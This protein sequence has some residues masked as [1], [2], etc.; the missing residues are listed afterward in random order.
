ML[1]EAPTFHLVMLLRRLFIYASCVLVIENAIQQQVL[2]W[3]RDHLI[4]YL[5]EAAWLE[6]AF[7]LPAWIYLISSCNTAFTNQFWAFWPCWLNSTV[8]FFF[9]YTDISTIVLDFVL[10][11]PMERSYRMRT[12]FFFFCFLGG[13]DCWHP[14]SWR[15]LRLL[16][17]RMWH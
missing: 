11:K 13:H 6:R 15:G 1:I 4:A 14:V 3:W 7:L 2:V 12:L 9:G 5:H 16:S 17:Q 10:R 8:D